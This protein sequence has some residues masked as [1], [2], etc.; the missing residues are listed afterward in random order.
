MNLRSPSLALAL[1]AGL[2]GCDSPAPVMSDDAG[3]DAGPMEVDSGPPFTCA[4]TQV[5]MGEMGTQTV[6]V[7]TTMTAERPRDLGPGC[8]NTA[9]E[10]RW[11]RQEVIEYH[12]P[13]S[14]DET[15]G[16]QLETGGEGT[17]VDLAV[18]MQVR[19]TCDRLPA[20][21]FPP[22]CFADFP[23]NGGFQA[24][25]GDVRYIILTGFSDPPAGAM[26]V[27]EGRIQLDITAGPVS[28][29]TVTGA[30]VDLQTV[31]RIRFTATG[32]D[33]EGN[34]AGMLVRPY[35]GETLVDL[36]GD[37]RAD[38]GS[39]YID[40]A[41]ERVSGNFSGSR[42]ISIN[43]DGTNFLTYL[44][45]GF[46]IDRVRVEVYDSTYALAE[47]IDATLTDS[48][49]TAAC[50]RAMPINVPMPAGMATSASATGTLIV[51]TRSYDEFGLFWGSCAPG[52][53]GLGAEGVHAIVVPE[54]RFDLRLSTNA[55]GSRSTDTVL[56]VRSD[57][58][59]RESEL[60]CSQDVGSD[61][62]SEVLLTDVAPGTYYAFVEQFDIGMA[63]SP[64]ELVA[65]L[66]P[67]LESG[68]TCDPAGVANRCGTGACAAATMLCP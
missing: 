44:F 59:A 9:A 45:R 28:P 41:F 24:Q 14:P 67:V 50:G 26:L 29:P 13:G 57:C 30:T 4:R 2:A 20:Q 1:L 52:Q 33:P 58:D 3:T 23:A 18:V 12:V 47:E 60:G 38:R 37:M 21:G 54:G 48:A 22:T 40:A 32:M 6:M 36:N 43:P 7:D 35:V 46:G 42:G 62:Q 61:R 63:A 19:E 55:P 31:T 15:V 10:V 64:Y 17:Q 68:A 51:P 53:Q 49:A 27:D 25:G 66:I 39:D 5:L 34:A 56:Y 8:G 65:T 16:V 11:A